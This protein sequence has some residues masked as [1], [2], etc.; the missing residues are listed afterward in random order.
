MPE[1]GFTGFKRLNVILAYF[2]SDFA[3]YLLHKGLS[4]V[5]DVFNKFSV[6]VLKII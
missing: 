4:N 5:G 6:I 1:W 2:Y 3:L